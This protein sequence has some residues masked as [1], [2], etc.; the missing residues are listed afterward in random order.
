[1]K[2]V[3]AIK[4]WSE[5]N[6]VKYSIPK[7]DSPAYREIKA[8]MDA[9]KGG[10]AA[11]AKPRAASK[12]KEE[13]PRA[14]K[15]KAKKDE[16]VSADPAMEALEKE[17]KP[18]KPRAKKSA[19]LLGVTGSDVAASKNPEVLL[20]NAVNMH[21]PVA[22]P[23]AIAGDLKA[24]KAEVARIRKPRSLPKLVEPEKVE[25]EAPFSMQ[26]LRRKLGA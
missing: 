8:M 25:S 26:A 16:P 17:R 18:R 1:M 2:W 14:R 3:E 19:D 12:L 6:G 13:K 22:P 15:P 11:E 20:N 7:K 9:A 21:E 10:A 5:K 4:M 23:A 24:L